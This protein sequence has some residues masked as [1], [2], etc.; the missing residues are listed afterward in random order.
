M[1]FQVGFILFFFSLIVMG[2]FVVELPN[3]AYRAVGRCIQGGGILVL[4]LLI[5]S[6]YSSMRFGLDS[7]RLTGRHYST[8]IPSESLLRHIVLHALSW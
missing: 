6:I 1:T 4:S 2:E 5:P 3:P 8:T 7:L